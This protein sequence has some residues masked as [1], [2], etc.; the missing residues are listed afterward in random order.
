[1]LSDFDVVVVEGFVASYTFEMK[2]IREQ[3]PLNLTFVVENWAFV[4]I[5]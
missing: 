5:L 2:I 4:C 3:E 1:M